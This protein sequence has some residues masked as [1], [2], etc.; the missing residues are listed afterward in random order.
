[1]QAMGVAGKLGGE[2]VCCM[3]HSL[4][5]GGSTWQ[6]VRL[7]RLHVEAG[8]EAVL[9]GPPGALAP[10]AEEAGIE[11][12]PTSWSEAEQ[13]G[14]GEAAEIAGRCDLAIVHWDHEVMN[15][16]DPALRA[17]GRAGLVI[18]QMP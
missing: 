14:W 2:R 9:L 6:W 17:C 8:G 1:M 3:L 16:F 11:V 15:A 12:V 13:R 10:V 4:D 18:H 7:L 5:P